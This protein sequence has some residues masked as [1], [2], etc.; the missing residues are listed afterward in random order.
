MFCLSSLLKA[1]PF[2]AILEAGLPKAHCDALFIYY[3]RKR[4]AFRIPTNPL[5]VSLST[6][7]G[8]NVT[9]AHL[10][11]VL[12]DGLLSMGYT[13]N[14]QQYTTGTGPSYVCTDHDTNLN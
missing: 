7:V 12:G 10:F 14:V 1:V 2:S 13:L 6:V 3:S 11:L 4:M 8:T 9:V 5:S